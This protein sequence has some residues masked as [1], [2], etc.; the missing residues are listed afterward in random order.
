MPRFTK[1]EAT[2]DV[3]TRVRFFTAMTLAS[4]L[5]MPLSATAQ[6]ASKPT[7]KGQPAAVAPQPSAQPVAPKSIPRSRFDMGDADPNDPPENPFL[8]FSEPQ[9]WTARI[10]I[11]VT[12]FEYSSQQQLEV[13]SWNMDTLAMIFPVIRETSASTGDPTDVK[14]ELRVSERVYTKDYA[15][16]QGYHSDSIYTRWDAKELRGVR[17][18]GLIIEPKVR[19]WETVLNEQKASAVGWPKGDWPSEARGTFGPQFGVDFTEQ[20]DNASQRVPGLVKNWTEG[21]DPKSIPPLQLAKYL[22]GRVVELVQPAASGLQRGRTSRRR[23][24]EGLRL[25]GVDRTISGGRGSPFDISCVLAAVFREAGLPARIV[26]GLREFD[27]Y[28]TDDIHD[29]EDLH[30]SEAL[31]A[32]VEFFLY[33]EK[34]GDQGWIPVDPVRIRQQSSRSKPLDQPWEF[35]GTHDELDYFIPLSFHFHPPTTVRAYGSPGLWGWFVT[36]AAPGVAFQQ[37]TFSTFNTPVRG[38]D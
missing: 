9:N 24:F 17:E 30:G 11:D 12:A 21:R 19:S 29:A 6:P 36:P 8:E 28:D 25:L 13:Q 15:L 20:S 2:T 18:I 3:Q 5:M 23:G 26:I 16:I 14:G 34:T 22:T 4:A 35:F 33:D 31:H 27:E 38:G 7:G 10:Q 32:Y 1:A 37:L